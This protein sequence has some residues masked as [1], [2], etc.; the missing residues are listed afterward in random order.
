MSPIESKRNLGNVKDT[1]LLKKKQ[2]EPRKK[3]SFKCKVCKKLF[4]TS[5][6]LN[7]RCTMELYCKTCKECIGCYYETNSDNGL[8]DDKDHTTHEWQIIK[9]KCTECGL[10]S[11]NAT[12]RQSHMKKKH[13]L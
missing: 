1:S 3:T 12:T 8:P 6:D 9:N 13:G 10:L 4:Q 5:D 7:E 11:K 2:S